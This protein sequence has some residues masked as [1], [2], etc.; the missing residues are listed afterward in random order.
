MNPKAVELRLWKLVGT[1]E[2]DGILGRNDEK[3]IG[4]RIGRAFDGD[5]VLGHRLEQSGLGS[6]GGAVDFIGEEDVAEQRALLEQKG[7]RGGIEDVDAG[8][9]GGQ[10]VGGELHALGV[11]A[12]DVLGEFLS[13]RGFSGAGEVL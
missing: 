6:W 11:C 1:F 4:E 8:E 7:S 13:E 5:L 12:L 10:E 2:F 9:I 3:V